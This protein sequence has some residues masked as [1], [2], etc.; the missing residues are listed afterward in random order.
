MDAVTLSAD[1]MYEILLNRIYDCCVKHVPESKNTPK[2]IIP[3]DRRILMRKR[4]RLQ[5]RAQ[6]GHAKRPIFCWDRSARSTP[7]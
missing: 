6:R 5:Q 2:K 3:Y 1:E 4:R 7:S